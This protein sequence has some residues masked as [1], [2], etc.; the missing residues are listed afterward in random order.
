M[1]PLNLTGVKA[2]LVDRLISTFSYCIPTKRT[3]ATLPLLVAVIA[4]Q[5]NPV[6]CGRWR[7][8]VACIRAVINAAGVMSVLQLERMLRQQK[9]QQHQCATVSREAIKKAGIALQNRAAA[10]RELRRLMFA[11]Q[12][13]KAEL[14]EIVL[15]R[16]KLDMQLKS[17]QLALRAACA[18]EE[19]AGTKSSNLEQ[20][21]RLAAD[22]AARADRKA[23]KAVQQW[24]PS[25]SLDGGLKQQAQAAAL[26]SGKTALTAP[27]EEVAGCRAAEPQ[28]ASD[29]E[30]P[31]AQAAGAAQAAVAEPAVDA[32]STPEYSVETAVGVDH[33]TEEAAVAATADA[34][35]VSNLAGVPLPF[36]E[37]GA[38]AHGCT[39]WR[40]E[41]EYTDLI[42]DTAVSSGVAVPT[43]EAAADGLDDAGADTALQQHG[44][45][46]APAYSACTTSP[47][48]SNHACEALAAEIGAADMHSKSGTTAWKFIRVPRAAAKSVARGVA[49]WGSGKK[50]VYRDLSVHWRL[51]LKQQMRRRDKRVARA[52][53]RS[54]V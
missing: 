52:G 14:K 9:K 49:W 47:P 26:P 3:T 36:A 40:C 28:V 45:Y 13:A 21:V 7:T 35:E 53:F 41:R 34:E 32:P 51:C 8:D 4:E 31:Q 46:T 6:C 48:C 23:A 17:M 29:K 39:T 38:A 1:L 50:P 2:E 24:C 16:V 22:N 20:A 19:N 5:L 42:G 11:Q 18:T 25:S 10:K 43:A 33:A 54:N 15:K 30:T 27:A 37:V 44:N 12:Q